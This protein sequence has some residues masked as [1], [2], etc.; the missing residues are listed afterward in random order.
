MSST[1]ETERLTC[2]SAVS[3]FRAARGNIP[4]AG[5]SEVSRFHAA[6]GSIPMCYA[7]RNRRQKY[8]REKSSAV[9]RFCAARGSI[10]VL[11]A[12]SIAALCPRRPRQD[13]WRARVQ[14]FVSA[15]HGAIYRWC[16]RVRYL[17]LMPFGAVY[18]YVTRA[19]ITAEGSVRYAID[20]RDRTSGGYECSIS[21]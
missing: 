9:S 15:P 3:R 16:A 1:P 5:T 12:R 4:M 8:I 2:T 10:P 13:V 6:R 18:R 14:Y 21:G 17:A 7:R 20:A 19:E 11:Y